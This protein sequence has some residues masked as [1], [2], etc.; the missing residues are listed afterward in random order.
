M[1]KFKLTEKIF[2]TLSHSNLLMAS[3]SFNLNDFFLLILQA[4]KNSFIF[5]HL[6]RKILRLIV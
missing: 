6:E 1:V 3:P 5:Y 4:F 2:N